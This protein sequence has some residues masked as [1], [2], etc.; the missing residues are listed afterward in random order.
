MNRDIL[1]EKKAL[2][3]TQYASRDAIYKQLSS[4]E[5]QYK[6]MLDEADKEADRLI[7]Q[8]NKTPSSYTPSANSTGSIKYTGGKF[9]WPTPSCSTITS[10]FGSRMHPIQKRVITHRGIDIGA[11]YGAAILA[12]AD[13]RVTN[14]G[15]NGSYG[16]YIVID[17]GSGYKTLYAHCSVLLVS[18][19][20]NVSRGQTIANVGSTGNSTGPHLHFEVLI[21]GSQVNPMGYFN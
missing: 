12:A 4:Q 16:K 2:L 5:S 10:P 19:G 9:A 7:A 15:W 11:S 14:A 21:N 20:Q 1:A 17:H 8:I 6:K 3:A 13:G 18:A